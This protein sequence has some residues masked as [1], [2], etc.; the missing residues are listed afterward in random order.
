MVATFTESLDMVISTLE[1]WNRA[2]TGNIKPVIADIA[3]VGAERGKRIDLS[4][5]DYI[6]CYETAHNLSLIHISE[7]TRPY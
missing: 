6:L 2:N 4:R 5:H 1:N 7:P 3:T